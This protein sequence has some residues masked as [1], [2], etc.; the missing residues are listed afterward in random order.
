MSS[1]R[2]SAIKAIAIP[3]L[4]KNVVST[5]LHDGALYPKEAIDKFKA[6]KRRRQGKKV[7]RR[8]ANIAH[9]L[10]ISS[11]KTFAI[12]DKKA[13]NKTASGSEGKIKW[14]QDVETLQWFPLKVLFNAEATQEFE[15][16][17]ALGELPDTGK[18][19]IHFTQASLSV[20]DENGNDIFR[21]YFLMK[22]K[23][24]INLFDYIKTI[25]KH[26]IFILQIII[27]ILTAYKELHEKGYFHGDIK[28]ENI[29]IDPATGH[30]ELIDFGF[31]KQLDESG[32][33]SDEVC[34][35]GT[36]KYIAPEIWLYNLQNGTE[37]NTTVHTIIKTMLTCKRLTTD[38]EDS[39]A[40]IFSAEKISMYSIGIVLNELIGLTGTA[41]LDFFPDKN[42]IRYTCN[43]NFS[44]RHLAIFFDFL[45]QMQDENPEVRPT[46]DEAITFFK[47]A[48]EQSLA[49]S[50]PFNVSLLD[51]YS[52][53]EMKDSLIYL[54]I[55]EDEANEADI[56]F[57]L[58]DKKNTL[59]NDGYTVADTAFIYTSKKE[60]AQK[61]HLEYQKDQF[62]ITQYYD[63]ETSE[64]IPLDR[65]PSPAPSNLGVFSP[66]KASSSN[67][68][69]ATLK[70]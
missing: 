51:L 54:C 45:T 69:I 37:L 40:P 32:L 22:A 17:E 15:T 57:D 53:P 18:N 4:P 46:Y 23:L 49:F 27:N 56:Q 47:S 25:K 28:P 68:E 38:W 16:L 63:A 3:F 52:E 41:D 36:P 5:S 30:V 20:E 13:D 8:Q 70:I 2:H 11:E 48:L 67:S 61:I 14:C 60:L 12:A 65:A 58:A 26:P 43:E 50:P 62:G 35:S 55:Q 39:P 34:D 21:R 59:M 7:P 33:L 6:L 19:H 66:P 29:M 44:T 10:I 42:A 1:S 64:H 31:S 9:S 24:G